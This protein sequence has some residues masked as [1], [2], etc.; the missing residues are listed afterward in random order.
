MQSSLSAIAHTSREHDVADKF[1]PFD[2]QATFVHIFFLASRPNT[3]ILMFN[4]RVQ[5]KKLF[6]SVK[7][8]SS[9]ISL[10]D[11]NPPVKI[12]IFMVNVLHGSVVV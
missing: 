11:K 12:V 2:C 9:R 3:I 5:E 10:A 8:P 1:R 4:R 7:T 6:S